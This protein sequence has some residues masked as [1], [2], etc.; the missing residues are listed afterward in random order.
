VVP[1]DR[2]PGEYHPLASGSTVQNAGR[3][4]RVNLMGKVRQLVE[5]RWI[6]VPL[7]IIVSFIS[8]FL[9]WVRVRND[10]YDYWVIPKI[11]AADGY[12]NNYPQLRY[13]IFDS[14]LILWCVN[15]LVASAVS[16]RSLSSSGRI[17]DWA[18]RMSVA[19]FLLFIVL[20]LGGSLMIVARSHG[21]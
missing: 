9:L 2:V 8:I 11:R 4:Y 5:H 1:L 19:Y 10:Y 15:G 7:A 14:V 3:M 13:T 16:L 6:V 20:I 12:I 17:S 18:F 21:Y